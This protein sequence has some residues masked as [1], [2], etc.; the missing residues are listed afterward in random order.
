MNAGRAT[1]MVCAGAELASPR[2]MASAKESA[3][4]CRWP[5]LFGFVVELDCICDSLPTYKAITPEQWKLSQ[6]SVN[7][8]PSAHRPSSCGPHN[9]APALRVHQSFPCC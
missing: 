9:R 1:A 4:A 6:P 8:E 3:L 2:I 5:A 7:D